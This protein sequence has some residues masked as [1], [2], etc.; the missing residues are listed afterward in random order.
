MYRGFFVD[1]PDEVANLGR[2]SSCLL[3]GSLLVAAAACGGSGQPQAVG[4]PPPPLLAEQGPCT[5][6]ADR[7]GTPLVW[8]PAVG[9]TCAS[10]AACDFIQGDSGPTPLPDRPLPGAVSEPRLFVFLRGNCHGVI[11][12]ARVFLDDQPFGVVSPAGAPL[13]SLVGVGKRTISAT[14][15]GGTVG[16]F[17]W[18][19]FAASIPSRGLV[20]RLSCR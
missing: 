2:S 20:Q 1:F 17:E 8:C 3:A 9:G 4:G 15:F 11:D 14:P 7:S 6:F 12:S 16:E 10:A 19:S 13:D 18:L 5:P